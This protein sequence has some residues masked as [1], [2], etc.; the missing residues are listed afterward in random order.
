MS[1][2]PVGFDQLVG[3][4]LTIDRTYR[5]GIRGT[6][7]DDPLARLLPVGNQGGFRYVGS[8]TRGTVKLCVLYTSGLETDWPDRLDVSTGDFSYFGDNRRPGS[9]LLMTRRRGNILLQDTFCRANAEP[10]ERMTVPPY[11]LFEK[12]GLGRD[13]LFRGLLAPGSPRLSPEEELVAVWRTT[14]R[15]SQCSI[16]RPSAGP[17]S[18]RFSPVIHWGRRAP[19]CGGDG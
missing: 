17:G 2:D 6:T 4:D 14:E 3:A 5:G 9:Q 19:A 1:G 16:C 10:V 15:I 8:P 7:A 13:V 11:L 12:S 18:T